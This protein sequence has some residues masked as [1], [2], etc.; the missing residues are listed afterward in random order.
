MHLCIEESLR[1]MVGVIEVEEDS[2]GAGVALK[3]VHAAVA[4]VSHEVKAQLPARPGL[5]AEAFDP[6]P[7]LHNILRQCKGV[8]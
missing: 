3:G 2:A 6:L 1:N 7:D 5:L 8:H 4:G